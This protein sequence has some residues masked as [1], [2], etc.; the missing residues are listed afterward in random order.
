MCHRSMLKVGHTDSF[1]ANCVAIICYWRKKTPI[2]VSEHPFGGNNL[3][4]VF[5]AE[6]AASWS[7]IWITPL[8]DDFSELFVSFKTKSYFSSKRNHC[9]HS[10]L[11]L[12]PPL[13][14][15]KLNTN[16]TGHSYTS[17]V[18]H[19]Q[20]NNVIFIAIIFLKHN[21]W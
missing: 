15:F 16:L 17:L 13:I 10:L 9:F 18:Y 2:F 5:I 20:Y 7:F 3:T 8:Y 11:I 12:L 6:L 21:R 14:N 1:S 19:Q 4:S